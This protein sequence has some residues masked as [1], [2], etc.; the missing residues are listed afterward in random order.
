MEKSTQTSRTLRTL[1]GV[2][3][4]HGDWIRLKEYIRELDEEFTTEGKLTYNP[5]DQTFY[6]NGE[7][8]VNLWDKFEKIPAPSNV[9]G[10]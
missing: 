7:I 4:G 10:K 3:V 1:K 9:N 8:E 6:L 2:E 5:K